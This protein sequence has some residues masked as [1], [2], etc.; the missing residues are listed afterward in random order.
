[1]ASY[2]RETRA[3]AIDIRRFDEDEKAFYIASTRSVSMSEGHRV[4]SFARGANGVRFLWYGTIVAVTPSD[5]ET[6]SKEQGSS[7][8]VV[9]VSIEDEFEGDGRYLEDYA[10]S[11]LKV[12]RYAE[13][14]RHFTR[15]YVSLEIFD[16][17]TIV[18]GWIFW[19]RTAFGTFVNALPTVKLFEYLRLAAEDQP[20][21]VI[22]GGDMASAWRLLKIFIEDEYV[23]PASL[24]HAAAKVL[25]ELGDELQVTAL[26]EEFGV[27]DQGQ[28]TDLLVEQ[29]DRFDTFVDSLQE[30]KNGSLLR[31][32]DEAVERDG[33]T[34]SRFEKRFA[35]V[36]WPL[37]VIANY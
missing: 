2:Y 33:E 35:E 32:F 5:E 36:Q 34:E 28:R 15:S 30:S 14:W 19:A 29:A 25:R 22:R 21:L 27:S 3:W 17:E 6:K 16:F 26:V 23:A 9:V 13:S 1:M 31:E 10:F 24:F 4:V 7:T 12:R 8:F 37:Y 11:L 18:E 20:A